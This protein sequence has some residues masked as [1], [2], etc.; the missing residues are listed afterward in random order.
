MC[1]RDRSI[2]GGKE[3]EG[4]GIIRILELGE[5]I[6]FFRKRSYALEI[7]R[8]IR[9]NKL[10]QNKCKNKIGR[11]QKHMCYWVALGKILHAH[12]P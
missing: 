6:R 9:I 10:M 7:N 12:I 5:I 11:I 8:K 3:I 2:G 1:I 4:R